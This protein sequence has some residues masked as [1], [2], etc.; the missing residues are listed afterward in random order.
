VGTGRR[1]RI[2]LLQSNYIPW[3]GYFDII[4]SVDEFIL[5]DEVQY[6]RSDWRN[7]NRIKTP[8]GTRWLT[9]PVNLSGKFGQAISETQ[10]S[11]PDWPIAHWDTIKSNC[12]H[13]PFF[14]PYG[15]PVRQ[16]LLSSRDPYLSVINRGLIEFVCRILKIS[17][18]ITSSTQYAQDPGRTERL[19]SI[20]RQ[21]GA[22]HY[23]S[24]P[25]AKAYLK[26]DLFTAAGIKVDF[27]DYSDY[28]QYPQLH[29]RFEHSVS[30]ID[31]L[32]NT[33]P[34]AIKFMKLL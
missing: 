7:R 4:R 16:A 12:S 26:E 29:G 21:A 1:K 30:V 22:T 10:V 9:I 23:L 20:C 6:T 8:Q 33:G 32:F 18:P 34:D 27:A 5:F 31:L 15:D 17:T 28:P 25:A 2:A 19:I 11:N 13:A 3:K 14:A 24:G